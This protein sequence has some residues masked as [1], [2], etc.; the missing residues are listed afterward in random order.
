MIPIQFLYFDDCPSHEDALKRLYQVMA[1]EGVAAAVEIIKVETEA[2]AHHLQ[3][4][5]SPTILI[6][7]HDIDPLP[8][9][10]PYRL[11]CR[12]Y[13]WEDG[14]ISPLPSPTMIRRAL[15]TLQE[16]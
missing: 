11:T 2:Q 15:T 4:S 9:E 12:T 6:A 5:G 13:H 1:E 10:T 7:G 8:P 16:G 14:R 3:F